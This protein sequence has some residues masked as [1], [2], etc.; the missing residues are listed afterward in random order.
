MWP[1]YIACNLCG[2]YEVRHNRIQRLMST[3]NP[4]SKWPYF[5]H[6]V[7]FTGLGLALAVLL[8]ASIDPHKI[9]VIA[10]LLAI[11][12]VVSALIWHRRHFL[13]PVSQTAPFNIPD[14]LQTLFNTMPDP[15]LLLNGEGRALFANGAM[16]LLIGGDIHQKHLSVL[17]RVPALVDA[18]QTVS[19]MQ[20]L[21]IEF[22]LPIP[23]TRHFRAHL[24]R[25][26][27]AG[28][29]MLVLHDLTA[30]KQSEEMRGDFIAHVSHE[31]RTPL[32]AISGFIDTL[33]GHAREDRAAREQFLG[34]MSVEAGRM[35]R[36]ID[37]LLS[38][39]RIELNEH[40]PP[41][42]AVTLEPL[43]RAAAAT[44]QPLAQKESITLHVD[45]P[46]PL[47]PFT[48]DADELTQLVQNLLHNA[49]KYGRTGGNVWLGASVVAGEIMITIR[50]DGAGIPRIALSR[51]TERFYRVDVQRSREKG[52]TGL[53]LAIVKHIV[54][55]HGG[56][57]KIESELGQGSQFTAI[58]PLPKDC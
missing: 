44:L 5:A 18:L 49:I 58:F 1:R 19:D 6:A 7:G 26:E 35:R 37:D 54:N 38:L 4:S 46:E 31:L 43:L 48:A 20:G 30:I 42:E 45:L 41:S 40:V 12:A 24:Q 9:L 55:R 57:L 21:E 56:R 27:K 15:I 47:P 25:A 36:L 32:A 29:T 52:G 2:S 39:T 13:L 33:L 10:A 14:L 16:R 17:L 22:T 23:V 28:F 11:A 34:I 8:G 50:D 51:L 3:Q 53:G